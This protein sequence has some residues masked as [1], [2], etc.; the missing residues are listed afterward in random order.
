MDLL[1]AAL[2][3][4]IRIW[5]ARAG[6]TLSILHDR[7][8]VLG[9]ATV[10]QIV[11]FLR[12]PLPEFRRFHGRVSIEEVIQVDSK[13]DPRVQVAD[14]VAGIGRFLGTTALDRSALPFDPQD[15]IARTSLW[16]DDRSWLALTGR[17]SVR[18]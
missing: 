5:S 12:N 6:E 4:T 10:D 3:E 15:Y 1:L 18:S 17:P 11:Y 13:D 14:L 7:Q 16:A 8:S 2:P 9:P